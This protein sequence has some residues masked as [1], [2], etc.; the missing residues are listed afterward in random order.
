MCQKLHVQHR[1]LLFVTC[2]KTKTA[3]NA[4]LNGWIPD[5]NQPVHFVTMHA[6]AAWDQ[7]LLI[8]PI[9][10]DLGKSTNSGGSR[11]CR[12]HGLAISPLF[13]LQFRRNQRNPHT[14]RLVREHT[15]MG[16][17]SLEQPGSAIPLD[18]RSEISKRGRK[19]F[20]SGS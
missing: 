17:A 16:D 15:P 13:P 2:Q 3:L 8:S 10:L 20:V 6:V 12:F 7:T 14:D 19:Y 5:E 18:Q 1:S 4:D 9:S 11:W